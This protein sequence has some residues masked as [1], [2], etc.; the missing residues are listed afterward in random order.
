[1]ATV[2]KKPTSSQPPEAQVLVARRGRVRGRLTLEHVGDAPLRR[3]DARWKGLELRRPNGALIEAVK[4]AGRLGPGESGEVSVAL[5]I[6]PRTPPGRVRGEL[7]V[8]GRAIPIVI[9][10][11][12][13]RV[14]RV[15]PTLLRVDGSPGQ[16]VEKELTIE[17]RGNVPMMVYDP[18]PIV[19]KP[20]EQLHTMVRRAVEQTETSDYEAFLNSLTARARELV[21]GDRERLVLV[22]V[23]GAPFAVQ[24]GEA[25][26][27]R[28]I[29]T[30][31][32][33]L[34]DGRSFRSRLNV[35]GTRVSIEVHRLRGRERVVTQKEEGG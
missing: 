30:L 13:E 3:L 7:D 34:N 31:P 18:E 25:V 29:W 21:E 28:L 26:V 4:L 8:G 27:T 23:E 15:A 17:N 10:V 11:P 14:V 2:R 32:E 33:N 12:E 9:V 16:Q 5:T 22:R 24:P 20:L 19:L 6:D 1:M 35:A